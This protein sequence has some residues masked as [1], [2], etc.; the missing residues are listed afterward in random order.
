MIYA[1]RNFMIFPVTEL[2]KIDFSQ[3]LETSAETVRVSA[4]S[5]LT[6]VKW[7]GAEPLC[8]ADVVDKQGPYTYDE[9][10][11]LLS[12][13]AWTSPIEGP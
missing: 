11:A 12:T 6:F 10:I 7:D 5:A 3:V 9:M 13:T 1:D 2:S 8:L 4:D